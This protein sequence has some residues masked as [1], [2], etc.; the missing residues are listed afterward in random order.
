MASTMVVS[1]SVLDS[2]P[3]E[4]QIMVRQIAEVLAKSEERFSEERKKSAMVFFEAMQKR[5]DNIFALTKEIKQMRAALE[6]SETQHQSSLATLQAR[7]ASVEKENAALNSSLATTQGSL[8]TTQGLV[9][10]LRSEN[11]EF[12]A[13]LDALEKLATSNSNAIVLS[14]SHIGILEAWHQRIATQVGY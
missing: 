5:D 11:Q 3:I 6:A 2:Q 9:N 13:K 1:R 8:S 12:R 4:R 14:A 7:V 10:T